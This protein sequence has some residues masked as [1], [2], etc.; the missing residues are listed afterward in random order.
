M[1]WLARRLSH[2]PANPVPHRP[3]RIRMYTR[4]GCH[5]C[6]EAWGML[7]EFRRQYGFELDTADVDT[8]SDL[9]ARYGDWVP[10]VAVNGKDRFRGRINRALFVRLLAAELRR[11]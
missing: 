11:R 9:T 1:R 2:Q 5:L 10:V 7:V 8:D 3:L 4:A 6:D